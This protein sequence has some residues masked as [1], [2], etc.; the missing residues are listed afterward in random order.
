MEK[1]LNNPKLDLE[2]MLADSLESPPENIKKN[3][4]RGFVH[5]LDNVNYYL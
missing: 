5:T 2:N 3:S 1:F 4:K